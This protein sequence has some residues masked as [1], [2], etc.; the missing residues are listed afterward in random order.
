MPDN[1]LVVFVKNPISGQVKTRI[2]RTVGD[3]KA[4]EVYQHLLRYTQAVVQQFWGQ[5]VVYY[6]DFVNPD[7]GWNGY[8]KYEQTGHDLGERMLNAFREQFGA[9]AQ[10]VVIIGSDCLAITPE[11]IDQA[12]EVLDTRDVVIGPA[13]DGGYYLL[14]MT[15][16]HPFLFN[17][18]PWSQPELGLR[19]ELS[20]GQHGLSFQRLDQL[21][22]ID[23]W[24]DYEAYL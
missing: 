10:K 1:R 16:L 20:L 22:D 13:T 19:T 17:D 2:A 3:T 7:D 23:E 24:S 5:C 6:G 15:K 4:V 11:H 18:M 9:G 14:G 21:T 8:K 12:F